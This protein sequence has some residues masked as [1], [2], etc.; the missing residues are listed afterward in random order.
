M[1][2]FKKRPTAY[3]IALWSELSGIEG[4]I[5]ELEI[6]RLGISEE[7]MVASG[8]FLSSEKVVTK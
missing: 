3:E 1:T 7:L 4:A 8:V 2:S 6:R 5:K